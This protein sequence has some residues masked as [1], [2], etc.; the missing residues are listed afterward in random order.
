MTDVAR[1]DEARRQIEIASTIEELHEGY[2]KLSAIETYMRNTGL[3]PLEDIQNMAEAKA[4]AVWKMGLLL[5]D[6]GKN[7]SSGVAARH[8][9]TSE[10]RELL[11]GIDLNDRT[12]RKY[13]SIST[14]P[15]KQREE[16]FARARE[17]GRAV[18]LA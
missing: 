4:L 3:Y 9:G 11:D 16:V 12:A 1:I 6:S 18:T 17:D 15:E 10:Y 5:A 7:T 2:A 14:L 8:A 13:Q